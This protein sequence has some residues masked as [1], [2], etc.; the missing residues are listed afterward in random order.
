MANHSGVASGLLPPPPFHAHG[1]WPYKMVGFQMKPSSMLT[2]LQ[3]NLISLQRGKPIWQG[4]IQRG[5]FVLVP[6]PGGR[7]G[8]NPMGTNMGK[9]WYRTIC[10]IT[11][12]LFELKLF[13][14]CNILLNWKLSNFLK[15]LF[16][17][18]KGRIQNSIHNLL[19]FS[20][21]YKK[22]IKNHPK[23]LKTSVFIAPQ[24]HIFD[25]FFLSNFFIMIYS[26]LSFFV[27][28]DKCRVNSI[29]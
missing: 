14:Y 15:F 13:L 28:S 6:P 2:N 10:R 3:Q 23:Q 19:K 5:D 27:L 17:I 25:I 8:K 29:Y 9:K 21:N 4:G 20:V 24:K 18:L 26:V 12:T 11:F 1:S 7:E 16:L 22:E